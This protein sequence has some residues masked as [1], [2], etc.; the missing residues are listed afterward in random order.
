[1][2][3]KRKSGSDLDDQIKISLFRSMRGKLLLSFLVLALIPLLAVSGLAYVN[4]QKALED[5]AFDKLEA[6]LANR[7]TALEKFLDKQVADVVV[8]TQMIN[9]LHQIAAEK[10]SAVRDLKSDFI[11]YQFSEWEK[12]VLDKA[13]EPALA[14]NLMDLSSAFQ[15]IGAEG[16]LALDLDMTLSDQ[17]AQKQGT[18]TDTEIVLSDQGVLE[19]PDHDVV[20][21][22]AYQN[23]Q[24]LFSTL[25]AINEFQDIYLIDLG[26]NIVYVANN[27][28]VLSTNLTEG[29]YQE[30]GL[31]L[32]YQ[33]L[34]VAPAG[35]TMIADFRLF[36]DDLA[37]FIGAG[38][39]QEG[40]QVGTLIFQL[41]TAKINAIVQ[42]RT[43]LG[44][45]GETYL[46][47]RLGDEISLRSDRVVKYGSIGD[48][49]SGF[50]SAE[51][52]AGN[53]GTEFKVGSTGVLEI[54]AYA[55]LDMQGLNWGILTTISAEEAI[56][57]P[58]ETDH[59]HEGAETLDLLSEYNAES[60][61]DDLLL[62]T[63]DGLIFYTALHGSDYRTNLLSGPYKD[64]HLAALFR[65]VME[66]RQ[67][68]MTDFSL[69]APA[70]GQ[71]VAFTAAPMIHN[72][73]VELV[74]VFRIS[75]EHINA[76]TQGREGMGATGETYLVGS[77]LRMRSD[78]ILDPVQ[79]SVAAS[80]AGTVA[81][82]GV[83]TASSRA[84]LGGISDRG[85]TTDYKGIQVLSVYSPFKQHGLTW[86]FIAEKNTAEAFT[87]VV[88]LRNLMLL[89]IL[90]AFGVVVVVALGTARTLA[91]PISSLNQTAMVVAAGD[92]QVEARVH[93]RDETGLLA[94]NFNQMIAKLRRMMA[95]L[96]AKAQAEQ[97]TKNYLESTVNDYVSYVSKVSAGNLTE[98]LEIPHLDDA[99]GVLG[100]NLDAM[101][102]SLY[103]IS[104]NIRAAASEISTSASQTLS[105][106]SEQAATASQQAAAIS[107]TSSTIQEA[108]QTAEQSAERAH[109]VAEMAR[110]SLEA[111]GQGLQAVQSSVSSMVNIKEQVNTIAETILSLSEQT[112]RVGEIIE[113]VNDLADQSN[114]LALNAAIE[115]ARAGEAGKGF[116]VVAGEVRSLAEQSKEATENVREILQEIQKSANAAVMV[117]EEGAKRAD[118]GVAQV[119]QTGASIQNIKEQVQEVAQAAQQIAASA[120]QQLAGMDQIGSAMGS[121]NQ[122]TAQTHAGTQQIEKSTQNLNALAARLNKL[123]E[124]Y[125]ISEPEMSSK[126][127]SREGD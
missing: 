25:V 26:G 67:P 115:A 13:S 74:A 3:R 62:V 29:R 108:R 100:A 60:G 11:L 27:Q 98:V 99:L 50:D 19:E 15:V 58:V 79:H 9:G 24:S 5:A 65:Q 14:E 118:L 36:H 113:A 77:D 121:I 70:G 42:D 111:A 46:I 2:D 1:M 87:P 126:Q 64:T 12:T 32:L 30:G 112:Q 53:S 17:S 96:E 68:A 38:L 43:S 84:A 78:S 89:I 72:G 110:T 61:N 107:Q 82:N 22:T 49:K 105:A 40:V 95:E 122:A 54:T 8:L 7:R 94:R 80:F 109:H 90:I 71:P 91:N 47:G 44:E 18:E 102:A 34:P 97:E 41:D 116:A 23:I 92:L 45:T 6:V 66:T 55:P 125:K 127:T 59:Q 16:V 114:L 20:F 124:I 35:Q 56:A 93:F 51:A 73:E 4:A 57:R 83:D 119:N 101:T 81:K 52:L 86:A 48:P 31:A 37:M 21:V 106:T 10:N 39:Y 75:L 85:V 76:I 103:Q 104:R 69:Y 123:V 117:T 28:A 63:A 88:Q 33:Q 120:Q